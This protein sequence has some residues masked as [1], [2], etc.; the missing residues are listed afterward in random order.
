MDIRMREGLCLALSIP[1]R[2]YKIYC[3]TETRKENA[4]KSYGTANRNGTK[5]LTNVEE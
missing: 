1:F 3:G 2:E 4:A 5:C